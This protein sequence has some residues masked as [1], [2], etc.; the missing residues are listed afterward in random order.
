MYRAVNAAA[1]KQASIGRVHDGIDVL[2]RDI[3]LDCCNAAHMGSLQGTRA[4]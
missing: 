1:P 2:A 3:P 4:C